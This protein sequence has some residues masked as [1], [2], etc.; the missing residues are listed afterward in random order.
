LYS[1]EVL[2]NNISITDLPREQGEKKTNKKNTL[3]RPHS[4]NSVSEEGKKRRGV[5]RRGI[6]SL[7]GLVDNT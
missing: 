2:K 5:E 3:P 4:T 6:G 7:T 1:P